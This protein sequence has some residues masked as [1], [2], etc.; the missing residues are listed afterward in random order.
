MSATPLDSVAIVTVTYNSSGA[1]EPFLASVRTSE[2]PAVK[3]VVADNDSRDADE[4][5]RISES[6]GAEFVAVGANLGYGGAV[7][8]AVRT[9]GPDTTYILVSN[10]DV[11]LGS[12]ALRTLAD[13]LDANPGAAAAGPR[14]LNA[15]GTT[16][17]SAR[18]LPSLRTGVGHALLTGIWP[19]NPWTRAYRADESNPGERSV[20]WLSGSCVLLRRSAFDAVGG[21]DEGY[22][23]YFEDVD[24]GFRL[25]RAG[26]SNLYVPSARVVHTGA[27]STATE[28]T[29]MLKAHHDSAY[30]YL[31]KRYPG[32]LLAPL[33]WSLRIGLTIRSRI[34]TMRVERAQRRSAQAQAPSS[35]SR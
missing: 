9:L 3:V 21:F 14:V 19:G 27:H 10:P 7:N 8:A 6:Y 25:G 18:R 23:M 11:E 30:R 13:R 28:S 17:P 29:R 16:Y 26:W 5:K 4:S 1:L 32:A 15:D 12:G 2:S 20:G 34:V 33:R 35:P 24:L 31:Q 22:F